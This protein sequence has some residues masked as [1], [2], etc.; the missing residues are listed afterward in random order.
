MRSMLALAVLAITALAPRARALDA[1]APGPGWEEAKRT[2]DLVIFTRDNPKVG[3][4]DIDAVSEVD[5]PPAVVFEVVTD[6]D[7]Y[8]D[9]MPYVK[10]SK[11]AKR[12]SA[13]E[14]V[15]Y[16]LLSPPIVD[17]RDY[18]IDVKTTT[19]SAANQGVYTSAW[20]SRPSYGPVRDGVVRVKINTGAWVMEP[21]D[22]GKRTR[23]TYHLSTNPGG[24]I[25]TWIAN[26]SNTK[27][28]PNLF[29]AVRK[30]SVK[31]AH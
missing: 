25:P 29:Q 11:T 13:T 27:A 31:L 20:T 14:L 9:F 2:D 17:D 23:L 10:E 28:I 26:L 6:F 4:R 8:V 15:V 7:H 5:A 22:G 30:R 19:G 3:T 21:L 24:S 12:L 18:Y 1:K 16:S